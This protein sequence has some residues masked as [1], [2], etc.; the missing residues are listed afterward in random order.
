MIVLDDLT[1]GYNRHPAVH[2]LNGR[3]AEGSLTA[4]VGPNGAGKSTLLKGILGLI[5]VL[6]GH[7]TF[8]GFDRRDMAYAPQ[9]MDMDM[10]FPLSVLDAVC[11]GE[12][13]QVGAWGR[14]GP[15]IRAQARTAL[16][17]VGL[18]GFGTRSMDQLSVGQRQRVM[19]ARVIMADAQVILLD[20]PFAAVDSATTQVLIDLLEIWRILGR[21]VVA[22]VHDLEQVRAHFPETL[23]L[24]REIVA[25]GPTAQVLCPDNLAAMTQMAQGWDDHAPVCRQGAV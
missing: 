23:M 21:T 10:S 22:V 18:D 3:F 12:W 25:W 7:V 1:L 14:I 6:S 17:H 15:K 19:F 5:P 2:H 8:S 11:M 20:E 24:A 16:K 9:V 4:I 13:R